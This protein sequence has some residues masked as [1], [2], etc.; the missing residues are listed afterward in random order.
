MRCRVS[1]SG[2]QEGSS[3]LA[4]KGASQLKQRASGRATGYRVLEVRGGGA[5]MIAL[6]GTLQQRWSGLGVGDSGPIDFSA[7]FHGL[8]TG[9]RGP[10]VFGYMY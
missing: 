9:S 10:G 3:S 6:A 1:S 7:E 4:G 5:A 8:C 2:G